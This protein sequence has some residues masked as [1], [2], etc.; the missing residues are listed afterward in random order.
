MPRENAIIVPMVTEKFGDKLTRMRKA[1]G[2]TNRSLAVSAS[3]P[4]SLIAGLQSGHRRVGEFQARKIGKALALD[5]PELDGFVLDAVN[6]CTEKVLS[7]A[8][9]YPSLFLNFIAK[10]LR[11]AGI[12]PQDVCQFQMIPCSEGQALKLYL[13]GGRTAELHSTLRYP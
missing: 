2:L 6:T 4:A 9:E 12:T 13:N 1:S 8:K 10:Q 11:S 3:V 5:G 7:E